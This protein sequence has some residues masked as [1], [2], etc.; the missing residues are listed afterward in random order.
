MAGAAHAEKV[1]CNCN[2][3]N[4][5]ARYCRKGQ[6]SRNNGTGRKQNLRKFF[7]IVSGQGIFPQI[8]HLSTI[9]LTRIG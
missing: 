5:T 6:L 8:A 1:C 9:T 4:H 7:L 3:S 2:Q